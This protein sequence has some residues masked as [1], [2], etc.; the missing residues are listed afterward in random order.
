MGHSSRPPEEPAI[1]ATETLLNLLG[2]AALLLW[3]TRMVRTGVTRAYGAE[4][5]RWVGAAARFRPAAFLAGLGATLAVQSSTATTLMTASFAG[6]GLL[7]LATALAVVL[8]ADVGSTLAAQVLTFDLGATCAVLMLAGVAL[9]M[10]G[11]STPRRSLARIAIG[12]GIMLLALRLIGQ[13]SLPLRESPLLPELLA[14][15]ERE[16]LIA[17]LAAALLT[18]LCHSSLAMVLLIVALAQ[19]GVVGFPLALA[20]VLGANLGGGLPALVATLPQAPEARRVALGNVLFKLVGVAVAVPLI[21][22]A[23]DWLL[24]LHPDPERLVVNAH[25]AFNLALALVFLPLAGPAARLVTRL[26][27]ARKPEADP[28]KAR[29]LDE[30]LLDT[31]QVALTNAARE[32]LRMGDVVE[33]MLRDAKDALRTGNRALIDEVEKRDDVV[34]AL[35][36][37][38]KLYVTGLRREALDDDEARRCTEVI[39]F[40]TNLEHIGDIIDKNL[41]DLALKKAKHQ[42]RFSAEGWAEIEGLHA[43]VLGN[44]QLALAVF[45]SDDEEV[46]RKLLAEKVSLRALERQATEAH[47]E[48]LKAGMVE[49]VATSSLHLDVVRDLKRIHSHIVAVAYPVLERSGALAA[50]RLLPQA[51]PSTAAEDVPS[52]RTAQAGPA[53]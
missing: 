4:L 2:A 6:S 8:G 10:S 46:A 33:A 51:G 14:A 30:S 28:L 42:L 34:D 39:T 50:S 26:V 47:F 7:T 37:Q 41:M 31:P 12:L 13:A 44:L 35:H 9:F 17:V 38:I 21:Q 32:T 1:S 18:W 40:T 45:M 49:S 20:L 5:R 22:P 53:T 3:G 16:P 11:S 27:P 36:E 23:A 43:R 19:A 15:L 24:R 52:A 48:R 29:Y 25:T